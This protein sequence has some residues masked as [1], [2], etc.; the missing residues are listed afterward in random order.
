MGRYDESEAEFEKVFDINPDSEFYTL[1]IAWLYISQERYADAISVCKRFLTDVREKG[2]VYRVMGV[3]YKGQGD[4]VNAK[5]AF[6]K[7]V[8]L[9]PTDALYINYLKQL[10]EG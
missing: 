2:E 7:A 10:T 5:A 9:N 3:A 6:T 1:G 4:L 8:E